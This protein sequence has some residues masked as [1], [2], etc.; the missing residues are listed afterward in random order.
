MTDPILRPMTVEDRAAVIEL[1]A[2]SD[3]WKRLGYQAKDWDNYFTPLPQ[4]RDS[5][6]VDQD[7]SV[8]G[9]AVVRQKF[10]LGDYLELLG[11]AGWA[12]GKGL[13]GQLLVHVEAAVFARAKNL[14]ACVSD[15]ND[16]ARHFYK[17]HGYREIGPMPNF[18]IPGSAEILLR[19]SAGPARGK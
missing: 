2:D 16:Q 5:Y 3:P 11:V 8:A 13:G 15:F 14:F 17:K 7:G 1:L 6:V 12:R 19:K 4:G 9:I 10:L 18:L